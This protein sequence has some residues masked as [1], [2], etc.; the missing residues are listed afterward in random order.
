MIKKKAKRACF[1][2]KSFEVVARSKDKAIA[3]ICLIKNGKVL[4]EAA[5][6]SGPIEAAFNAIDKITKIKVEVVYFRVEGETK[7][8]FGKATVAIE[9]KR[10]Y[11]QAK[12]TSRDIIGASIS[13]YLK[14]VNE[15][16]DKEK[17][18]PENKWR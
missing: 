13:A 7:A 18:K 1:T 9:N 6:G 4:K 8:G 11:F 2:L 16:I 10:Y 17:E 5:I 12:A 15:M 3:T 14:A